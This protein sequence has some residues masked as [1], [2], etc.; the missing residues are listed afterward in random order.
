MITLTLATY[1][2]RAGDE[3]SGDTLSIDPA[4]ITSVDEVD[5]ARQINEEA[6]WSV[7]QTVEQI[8]ELMT[9]AGVDPPWI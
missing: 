8:E 3:V 6:E 7:T 2:N 9:G 5:G 1:T 4:I